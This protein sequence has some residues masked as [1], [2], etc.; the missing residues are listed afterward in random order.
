MASAIGNGGKLLVPHLPRTPQENVQFQRVVRRDIDIPDDS[1]RRVLPGMVGAVNYGTA[2]RAQ[3]PLMSIAGKTGSCREESAQRHWLG[4]FTSFAP[5]QDPR[6]A[7]AVILRGSHARGKYASEVAGGV[8]R[9]LGVIA[10]FAPKPGSQPMLAN[11]MIAPRPHIDPRKAAEVS[12]EEREDEAL[13]ANDAAKDVFVVSEAENNSGDA[14]QGARTQQ[15]ALQKTSKSVERPVPARPTATPAPAPT[16]PTAPQSTNGGA[17]RP[18]RVS[19]K[20]Q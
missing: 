3:S 20:Q 2:R 19:D 16:A 8:Y 18:R 7:V 15:P 4:L 6:L 13:E 11:D 17:Q 1:V 12:D 14:Q 9:R 10:R 5:V